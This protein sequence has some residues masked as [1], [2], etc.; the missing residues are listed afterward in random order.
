MASKNNLFDDL[1][2]VW[3]E[4][5]KKGQLTLWIL[6]ALKDGTK[7]SSEIQEFIEKNSEGTMQCEGT[8]L[9][10][11]LRKFQYVE[12]IGFSPGKGQSGPDRK[13][14]YLTLMGAELLQKFIERNILLFMKPD[15]QSLFLDSSSK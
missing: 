1:L 15:I 8:S 11:A 5:Y 4:T 9:Y 6:L 10:R 2:Q 7:Y 3:E 14:Y 12:I 13:Y